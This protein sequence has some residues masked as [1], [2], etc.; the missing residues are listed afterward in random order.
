MTPRWR[1]ACRPIQSERGKREEIGGC[2][3][4]P[5][6][7]QIQA[8]ARLQPKVAHAIEPKT[9]LHHRS[10]RN[11]DCRSQ[12]VVVPCERTSNHLATA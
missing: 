2:D 5:R 7:I 12:P 8:F 10:G 4:S 9:G 6:I 1:W 3:G 11:C